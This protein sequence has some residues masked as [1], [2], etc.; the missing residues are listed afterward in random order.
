MSRLKTAVFACGLV[1][2]L[3]TV[4]E[5]VLYTAEPDSFPE[6]ANISHSFPGI[7][8]ISTG[9]GYDNDFDPNVFALSSLTH[10]EPFTASTGVRVFG[11]N[12]ANFPTSFG[13]AG[14]AQMRVDF[15]LPTSMVKLDAIGNDSSDFGRLQAYSAANVLLSSYNTAS[16]ATSVFETMTVSSGTNIAYVLASGPNGQSVGF[17]YLRFE[18]VPEP[19]EAILIVFAALKALCI[20]RR[21]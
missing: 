14:G 18:A 12:D 5:A 20:R 6:G 4:S 17:D 10:A 11:T 19:S 1:T 7:A 13:G 9:A 2:M 8:V 16:L 15:S 3:A 21:R